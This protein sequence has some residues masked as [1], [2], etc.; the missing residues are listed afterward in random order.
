MNLF[1][2]LEEQEN[3]QDKVQNISLETNS[4][5]DIEG[6]YIKGDSMNRKL[7][8]I[9]GSS[10]LSTSFHGTAKDLMFA[11]TD[12]Q[13]ELAYKK[14]MQTSTG[15][16]T[17]GVYGFMKTLNKILDNQKPSHLAV[18]FDLSRETTFRKQM[19]SDYKGT[20]KKSPQPLREQ[21]KLMQEVL[22]YIG[23]PVLKS[24]EY[25]AD[26]FAGSL[27]KKFEDE[28][29]VYCHTKDHDYLQLISYNTRVW[30]VTSKCDKMFNEV[31]LNK[32]DFN[33]PDGVF[34]YTLT[35]FTDIQGLEYPEQIIDM[36]ALIGDSSDNI[37]GVHGVGEKAV[38]PLL[39][40]Y[41][42]IETLYSEIEGLT[43]KE[44]KEFKK[45]AKES[46][47]ITRLPLNNL[48]KDGVITLSSGDE[49]EYN[50]IFGDLTEEQISNQ[51]LFKSKLND[52][53]FPIEIKTEGGLELLKE[54][55]VVNVKLSAKES[56]FLSKEL[57]TIKTD[58]LEIQDMNL[59]DLLVNINKDKYNKKMIELEMKSLI[60]K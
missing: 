34:E 52:L 31:G 58:I 51:K 4:E 19:Y 41:K 37:P 9:D 47:G 8:I 20:R 21:F 46:L 23:V 56:A 2:F 39:K 6:E 59:D 49:I 38:I 50:C 57:A 40:E 60:R 48:L 18:V 33:L 42:N 28:I 17:N 35:T 55:D 54:N 53:R 1:D 44:E 10:L 12:E 13:R 22:E 16:Y 27:A 32:S 43:P 3:K 26:D 24:L 25:E 7:L 14:L 11:K 36:K 5:N 45:F 15:I 29:P 30:M